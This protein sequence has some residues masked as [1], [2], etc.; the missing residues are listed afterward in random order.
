MDPA[1]LIK[2]LREERAIKASDIERISR[3]I[4]DEKGN[5]EYYIAHGT[6][7]GI[8]SGSL[9]SIYKIFSLSV[10]LALPYEQ[11]LLV[12]GVDQ[13]EVSNYG[14]KPE[15]EKTHLEPVD[16][17][18]PGLR[19]QLHFDRRVN[20]KQTNLLE[21]N[22]EHWG[23]MSSS[24]RKRLDPLRF[25]YAL[26]G[27]EDD[28]M[29]ELIPPGSLVEI[30]KEQNAV[31]VFNWRTLRERPVYLIWH[32]RG[33]SCCWCQLD[34]DELTLLPHPSSRQRVQRYK[35][36]R[37]ANIIGRVVHA[38]LSFGYQSVQE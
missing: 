18:E 31:E 22:P 8:E 20:V 2:K 11:L 36:P 35:V 23:Q 1:K 7:A 37:D 19:F 29:G 16:L 28:S 38:W 12:F 6:L 3:S 24:L 9:P 5:P 33:Y 27:L 26:I 34:G 32:E 4:A 14:G 25:R 10:C 17:R 21:P 30:D 15:E 13:Q